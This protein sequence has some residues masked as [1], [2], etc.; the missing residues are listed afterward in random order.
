MDEVFLVHAEE[1]ERQA[2]E[3]AMQ[4]NARAMEPQRHPNFDGA[5]CAVCADPLPALRLAMG[6]VR[7]VYC[8]TRLE[9]LN[10]NLR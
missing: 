10:A 3:N 2:R 9:K 1:R 7:C 6:K 5:N 4:A 8:Q